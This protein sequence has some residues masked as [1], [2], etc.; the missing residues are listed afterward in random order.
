MP[1]VVPS[2]VQG[3]VVKSDAAVKRVA[4][5]HAGPAVPWTLNALVQED[6]EPD[7]SESRMDELSDGQ[8]E[9]VPYCVMPYVERLLQVSRMSYHMPVVNMAT[10]L[11]HRKPAAHSPVQFTLMHVT[12]IYQKV[13]MNSVLCCTGVHDNDVR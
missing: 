11:W 12:A 13:D 9:L 8:M 2:V 1:S 3:D 10:F 4:Q 6:D 7:D 5:R